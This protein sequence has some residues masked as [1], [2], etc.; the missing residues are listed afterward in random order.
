MLLSAEDGAD[1]IMVDAAALRPVRA[2]ETSLGT[3]EYAFDSAYFE[4]ALIVPSGES[5]GFFVGVPRG[6]VAGSFCVS[7]RICERMCAPRT[8]LF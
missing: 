8:S 5:F 7:V 2:D 6:R 3:A 1:N 4:G